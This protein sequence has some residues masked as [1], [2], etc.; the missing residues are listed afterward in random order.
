MGMDSTDRGIDNNTDNLDIR[1]KRNV[2]NLD[3]YT[4][5]ANAYLHTQVV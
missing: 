4:L 2:I 5:G 1:A 3:R